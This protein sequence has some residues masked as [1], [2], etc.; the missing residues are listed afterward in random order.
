MMLNKILR[1]VFGFMLVSV[2]LVQTQY[3]VAGVTAGVPGVWRVEVVDKSRAMD[4]GTGGLQYPSLM[5][6]SDGNPRI[7]YSDSADGIVSKLTYAQ[8]PAAAWITTT[9]DGAAGESASLALTAQNAPRIAYFDFDSDNALQYRAFDG[10]AW[11]QQTVITGFNSAQ[12]SVDLALDSAGKPYMALSSRDGLANY[13]LSLAV[14]N[15]ISWTV[16]P[17]DN[18]AGSA[19]SLAVD[20]ANQVHLSYQNTTSHTLS[21]ALRTNTGWLTETVGEPDNATI[22]IKS[23]LALDA[24]NTP[25]IVYVNFLR[26]ELIYAKRINGA[27]VKEKVGDAS[28]AVTL[29]LDKN[30]EPHIAYIE[31]GSRQ[32]VYAMRTNN[33]WITSTASSDAAESIS[34]A[35]DAGGLPVIAYTDF[36][37]SDLKLARLT[38]NKVYLP[39]VVRK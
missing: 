32:P 20:S 21:Y 11:P 8:K 24:A 3:S 27:W 26:K 17:V 23:S 13:K 2:L 5:M 30:G 22:I 25:H 4:E 12:T 14:P 38:R 15:G 39:L 28:Q 36:D 18:G 16:E 29:A 31:A 9:V 34:L 19:P 35:L 1:P 6:G 37:T 10:T 7:A 33:I